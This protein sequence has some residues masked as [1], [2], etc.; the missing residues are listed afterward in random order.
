[1]LGICHIIEMLKKSQIKRQEV[2]YA[3]KNH[4]LKER[5]LGILKKNTN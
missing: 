3:K 2:G 4:K 5:E 1:M